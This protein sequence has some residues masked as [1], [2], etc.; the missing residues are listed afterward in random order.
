[1]IHITTDSCADL[2]PELI[3]RYQIRAIPLQVLVNGRNLRDGVTV[4]TPELFQSVEQSGELPKTS[5]PSVADFVEFFRADD[6][7]IFI[8]ISAQL[9]ATLQSACI[10][11][12]QL[13]PQHIHIIDSLNL[14][15]GHG[16]LAVHAAET[17]DAGA[18]AEEIVAEIHR[19]IPRVRTSFIIDTLDYLHKGG[20]CSAMEAVV[21]SLL[22]IR[23][24][25]EV[26]ADGTLGV[27]NKVRGSRK[28]ALDSMLAEFKSHLP[29]VDLTRVFVTHTGCDE[30]AL[31]LKSELLKLAPIQEVCITIA[32]ATVASHCGPNTIGIIFLA[33]E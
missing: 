21:G 23:P 26:R 2:S 22:K 32:G 8:G 1:M 28:K 7:V 10:A 29:N 4:S 9:S 30:D 20:R 11:A 6:E 33:N 12:E 14:S 25:I 5:A 16:L 27:K 15:T 17:R 18:S 19:R 13:L 3:A 31:F 24:V